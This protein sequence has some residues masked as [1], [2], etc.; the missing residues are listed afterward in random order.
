MPNVLYFTIRTSIDQGLGII[1]DALNNVYV[2]GFYIS[3]PV[4]INSFGSV[5]SGTVNVTSYGTLTN[6]GSS[7]VFIVKYNTLGIVQWATRIGGVNSEQGS[8]ITTDTSGNVYVTGSYSSNPVTINSFGSV[9]GGF[10]TV[11]PYGI[12]G[13]VG[14]NN[15]FIVKYNTSGIAQWATRIGGINNDIGFAITTDILNNVYVTGSY[16]SN[17]VTINSF[18]SVLGGIIDVTPYGTLAN[19]GSIDVFIVKYDTNGQIL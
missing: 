6:I 1:T 18:G 9:S 5:S 13:N 11:T 15:V 2:T 4:T 16:S 17:P 12:L 10:I 14:I 8:A 19:A 3:N 7:D